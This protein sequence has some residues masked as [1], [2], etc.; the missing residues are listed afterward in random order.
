MLVADCGNDRLQVC[1]V[2]GQWSVL[3]LQ[4]PVTRPLRAAVID[5]KLYVCSLV[6]ETLSVYASE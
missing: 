3:D 4:P 6:K 2:S 5:N 1:D